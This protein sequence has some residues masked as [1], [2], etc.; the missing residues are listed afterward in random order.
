M[1]LAVVP[2]LDDLRKLVRKDDRSDRQIALA[3]G[4]SPTTFSA[5]MAARRGLSMETAEK[6]AEV[7]GHPLQLKDVR[8]GGLK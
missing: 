6:L 3:A 8:K 1:M 5:F 2:I 7:L 4:I